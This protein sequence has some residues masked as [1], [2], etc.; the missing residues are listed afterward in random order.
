VADQPQ[1]I[2]KA[3]ALVRLMAQHATDDPA[4]LGWALRTFAEV[5]RKSLS[6]VIEALGVRQSESDDFA[7]CLR[8]SGDRFAESTRLIAKRFD[9]DTSA[10]AALLRHVEVLS[11]FDQ[12]LSAST[13]S[14]KLLA[15]R[16]RKDML[17]KPR[18]GAERRTPYRIDKT[19]DADES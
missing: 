2:S 17:S 3:A 13:D 15:A 10:L 1:T 11:A 16:M 12:G 9:I 6:A 18:R 19:E 5:E 4:Y 7:V 14:G 8:P